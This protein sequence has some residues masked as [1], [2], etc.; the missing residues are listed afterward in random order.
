MKI[1]FYNGI[2]FLIIIL[3]EVIATVSPEARAKAEECGTP[4]RI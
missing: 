1:F 3:L 2:A 4:A